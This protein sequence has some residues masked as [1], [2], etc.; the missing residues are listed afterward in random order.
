MIYVVFVGLDFGSEV[1]KR[2]P[3]GISASILLRLL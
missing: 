2:H 3:L 1:H